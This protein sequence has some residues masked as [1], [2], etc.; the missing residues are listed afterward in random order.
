[1]GYIFVAGIIRSNFSEWLRK[2][3]YCV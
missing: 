1:M 2:L 3:P